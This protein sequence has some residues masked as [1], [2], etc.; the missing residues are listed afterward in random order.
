MSGIKGVVF[1]HFPFPTRDTFY[2]FFLYQPTV[3]AFLISRE[4][5]Q[6]HRRVIYKEVGVETLKDE[7]NEQ[8]KTTLHYLLCEISIANRPN[9]DFFGRSAIPE[10]ITEIYQ[11]I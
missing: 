3:V 10:W 5:H 2:T 7:Q 9:P 8:H 1:L 11:G 4:S 6:L